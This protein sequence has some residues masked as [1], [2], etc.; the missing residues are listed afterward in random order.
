MRS[1]GGKCVRVHHDGFW[2]ARSLDVCAAHP[3]CL[4]RTMLLHMYAENPGWKKWVLHGCAMVVSGPVLV[5]S[6]FLFYLAFN[7]CKHVMVFVNQADG[8]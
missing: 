7:Y 5:S 3:L 4:P 8:V 1:C 2:E 6:Y